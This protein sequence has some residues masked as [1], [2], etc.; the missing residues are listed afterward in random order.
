MCCKS[1][2][3]FSNNC[4]EFTLTIEIG[5]FKLYFFEWDSAVISIRMQKIVKKLCC[6][7]FL[8][9]LFLLF[10]GVKRKR[11]KKT[12]FHT[13]DL[14][15]FITNSE[16][17][18]RKDTFYD[19]CAFKNIKWLFSIKSDLNRHIWFKKKGWAFE[20]DLCNFIQRLCSL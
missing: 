8:L 19:I 17:I 18:Q 13:F 11:E 9:C 3:N 14:Q 4:A 16:H 5:S 6:F 7:F 20:F 1:S 2:V 15:T 12:S 10:Q